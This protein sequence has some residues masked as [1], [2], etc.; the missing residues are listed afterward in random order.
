MPSDRTEAKKNWLNQHDSL[1]EELMKL[2]KELVKTKDDVL[3][4]LRK[5]TAPA[6]ASTDLK[7]EYIPRTP[8]PQ[9]EPIKAVEVPDDVETP[10]DVERT[11]PEPM[12]PH[13]QETTP[14]K[15]RSIRDL[16]GAHTGESR[17]S[18]EDGTA[19]SHALPKHPE[20]TSY[21]A[22]VMQHEN[23][24]KRKKFEREKTTKPPRA[25]AQPPSEKVEGG[26][27]TSEAPGNLPAEVSPAP[28]ET[29]PSVPPIETPLDPPQPATVPEPE[30]QDTYQLPVE[31][32]PQDTGPL[33]EAV[34][35]D[36]GSFTPKETVWHPPV[37]PTTVRGPAR[38]ASRR[39]ESEEPKGG[40]MNRI[41]RLWKRR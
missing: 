29:K 22:K 30:H 40:F 37:R 9:D 4:D 6:A 16:I 33:P 32:P 7:S 34:A 17:E 15:E 36:A 2:K 10:M 24:L 27:S 20:L 1:Q 23:K 11:A 21:I 14:P 3:T 41:K 31:T 19:G 5:D 35:F 26:T 8:Q 25:D 12:P 38:S 13:A 18:V 28:V 39:E